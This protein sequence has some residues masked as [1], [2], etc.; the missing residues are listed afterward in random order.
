M[1]GLTAKDLSR[2]KKNQK[3]DP[4][5][6]RLMLLKETKHCHTSLSDFSNKNLS[7]QSRLKPPK[8]KK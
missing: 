3:C 6:Q 4:S 7:Y 2:G 1:N 5:V 8:F